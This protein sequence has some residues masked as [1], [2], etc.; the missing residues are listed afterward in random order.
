MES[1]DRR[2]RVSRQGNRVPG[3]RGAAGEIGTGPLGIIARG[4]RSGRGK[5]HPG[6]FL[7]LGGGRGPLIP[8]ANTRWR[9]ACGPEVE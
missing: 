1:L 2:R 9:V 7:A 8:T 3:E 6:A 4:G 5:R